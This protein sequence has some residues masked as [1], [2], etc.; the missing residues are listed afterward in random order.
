MGIYGIRIK[1]QRFDK[2][3]IRMIVMGREGW[4]VE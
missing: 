2:N 4:N 1:L 3:K